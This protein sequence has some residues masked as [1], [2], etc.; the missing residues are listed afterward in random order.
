MPWAIPH[1]GYIYFPNTRGD[2]GEFISRVEPKSST[3]EDVHFLD[4]SFLVG[5][6]DDGSK[7]LSAQDKLLVWLTSEFTGFEPF[8]L[9]GDDDECPQDSN[10]MIKGICGCGVPDIDQDENGVM[11]C[12][13]SKDLCPRDPTKLKPGFCGCNKTDIDT[14]SNGSADCLERRGD[15]C[16]YPKFQTWCGIS[17]TPSPTPGYVR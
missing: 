16:G 3:V 14:N 7:A 15:W 12:E 6:I 5:S 1:R 11:D 4:K 2:R 10:K 13:D 9:D 17:P 8:I